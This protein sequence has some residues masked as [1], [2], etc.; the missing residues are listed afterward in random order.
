MCT[1]LVL[2]L[3]VCT[4]LIPHHCIIHHTGIHCITC[5]LDRSLLR[6]WTCA[7]QKTNCKKLKPSAK[8]AKL[9][10]TEQRGGND[11]QNKWDRAKNSCKLFSCQKDFRK[12]QIRDHHW[13]P[14]H[15]RHLLLPHP[16]R[17][18]HQCIHAGQAL[19]KCR[20][21]LQHLKWKLNKHSLT[22]L[23]WMILRLNR[24]VVRSIPFKIC[25]LN[26]T[27]AILWYK[28]Y[29]KMYYPPTLIKRERSILKQ[30]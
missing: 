2:W 20:L 16:H 22:L 17:H 30:R 19:S 21:G 27:N 24:T 29:P 6:S 18:Q 9:P 8:L 26:C 10:C 7:P 11:H 13:R 5:I 23:V 14:K 15:H 12:H 4:S 3:P 25:V 1:F 28:Y